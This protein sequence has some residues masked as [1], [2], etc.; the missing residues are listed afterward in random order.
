MVEAGQT[1]VP[2]GGGEGGGAPEH[3]LHHE[4]LHTV[5]DYSGDV[6]EEEDH[7]NA[8]EDCSQ[9]C[10]ATSIFVGLHVGESKKYEINLRLP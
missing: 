8:D 9:I 6:T 7:H 5:E 1:Q 3:L 4:E 10:L 2:V